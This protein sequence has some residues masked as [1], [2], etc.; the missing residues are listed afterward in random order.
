MN[1]KRKSIETVFSKLEDQFFIEG[2]PA[3]SFFGF[4]TRIF[5]KIVAHTISQFINFMDGRPLN[6]IIYALLR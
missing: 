4:Y 5:S 2:N 6:Q 3:K 1:I